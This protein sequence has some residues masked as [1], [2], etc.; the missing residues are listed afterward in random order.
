MDIDART[1][2]A[3][4]T[5]LPWLVPDKGPLHLAIVVTLVLTA[6]LVYLLRAFTR[7]KLLRSFAIDD[8]LMVLAAVCSVSEVET[9]RIG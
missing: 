9:F 4:E 7:G 8:G 1:V 3:S 5:P 6:L 2:A